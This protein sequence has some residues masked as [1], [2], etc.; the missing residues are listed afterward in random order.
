MAGCRKGKRECTYPGT[1]TSA[2][3]GSTSKD[4]QDDASSATDDD[5][6]DDPKSALPAI[7]D[8]EDEEESEPQSGVSDTRKAS[9][10]SFPTTSKHTSPATD[11]PSTFPRGPARPQAQRTSSRSSIKPAMSQNNRWSSLPKDVRVYLKYHRESMSHHHYGFKYDAGNFLKTTFLEIAMNDES[12]A[13]LYGVVAFAAY[14]H[15]LK[16]GDDVISRFLS[17]YNKSISLLQQALTK[18][19]HSVAILLTILQLA[20]IEVCL[21]EATCAVATDMEAGISG[22][23]DESARSPEGSASDPH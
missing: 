21:N 6:D 18:K 2:T 7:A 1:P 3:S 19:R 10:A 17:Y 9:E 15:A 14:H 20:T 22:R 12:A 16:R 4:S 11:K 23:L 8:D 5:Y 13:L